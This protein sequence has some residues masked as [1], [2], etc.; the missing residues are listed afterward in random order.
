M[1]G[2]KEGE[3]TFTGGKGCTVIDYVIGEEEVKDRIERMKIGDKIDSVHQPVE[4]W[5]RKEES[6]R[7]E[8]RRR[9]RRWRG[10]W[11][12]GSKVFREK[13][14]GIKLGEEGLKREWE[15]MEG[16]VKKAL[17]ETEEERGKERRRKGG[18]WN[19]ECE[20]RKREVRKELR[21]WWK[22]GGDADG[23]RRKKQE[24]KKLCEGKKREENER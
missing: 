19:E 23:Y 4:V 1:R 5:L 18:C 10:V 9:G 24:Y 16:K 7:R 22:R 11:E 8:G 2:N 20:E 21:R 6:R 12:E 3:F 14:G 13:I 15:E 17:R